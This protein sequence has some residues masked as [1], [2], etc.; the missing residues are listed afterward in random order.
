M[1]WRGFC[2]RRSLDYFLNF[3][4]SNI[5]TSV[6]EPILEENPNRFVIFPIKHPGVMMRGISLR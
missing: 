2:E 3:L 6:T 4:N 5:M 1:V